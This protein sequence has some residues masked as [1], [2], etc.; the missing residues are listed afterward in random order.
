MKIINCDNFDREIY[1]DRLICENVNE[2]YA[3]IIV[4][5]LNDKFGGEDSADFYKA[6]TDDYKL[7]KYEW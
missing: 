6:V 2:Y 7:Y 5:V 3:G 1:D 4:K